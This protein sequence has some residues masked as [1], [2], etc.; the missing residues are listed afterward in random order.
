MDDR[1]HLSRERTPEIGCL[2]RGRVCL[3]NCLTWR[4]K[5]VREFVCKLGSMM[6]EKVCDKVCS[7]RMKGIV[8]ERYCWQGVCE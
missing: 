6:S 3:E 1:R 7:M 5:C 4:G 8:S 2:L